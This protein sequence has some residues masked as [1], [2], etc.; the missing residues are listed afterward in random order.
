[1][2]F[3]QWWEQAEKAF[4]EAKCFKEA[5]R[6]GWVARRQVDVQICLDVDPP[7]SSDAAPYAFAEAI[8]A[9]E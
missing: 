2:T 8:K 7:L 4:G 6:A 3:D 5:A 1:M 9:I